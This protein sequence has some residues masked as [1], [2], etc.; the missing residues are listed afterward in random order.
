LKDSTPSSIMGETTGVSARG[1]RAVSEDRSVDPP[2]A[3]VFGAAGQGVFAGTLAA[4]LSHL[5]WGL[6]LFVMAFV[7][8]YS[9]SKL[10]G[11]PELAGILTMIGTTV[12]YFA[13]YEIVALDSPGL[14]PTIGLS[15]AAVAVFLVSVFGAAAWVERARLRAQRSSDAI[16]VDV[17]RSQHW[18]ERYFARLRARSTAREGMAPLVI[19]SLAVVASA[20]AIAFAWDNRVVES[21]VWGAAF[22]QVIVL[23]RMLRYRMRLDQRGAR[24]AL[25]TARS[26]PILFLRPFALD[27]LPVSPL[28]G[29]WY[30]FLNPFAWLDKRT[31]EEHLSSTFEDVGPVIAIGRPGEEVAPLGAAREYAD[32]ATWQDV[33]LDRAAASQFV[34]MEVDATPGMAWELEHV[35]ERVGLRRV[36]IVLP[37]GPDLFEKRPPEWYRR[38]AELRSRLGFLPDVSDDTAAVLFDGDDRPILVAGDQSSVLGTL[39]AVRT[40][41][42]EERR[43]SPIETA[44]SG[45]AADAAAASAAAGGGTPPEDRRRLVAERGRLTGAVARR[46]LLRGGDDPE[47]L[48]LKAELARVAVAEGDLAKARKLQEAVVAGRRRRGGEDDRETLTALRE[49]A[50]TVRLQGDLSRART[51]AER[52]AAASGSVLGEDHPETVRARIELAMTLRDGGE[53]DAA[54]A[55]LEETLARQHA[56]STSDAEERR[57]AER[58]LASVL[59]LSGEFEGARDLLVPV[60]EE[61]RARDE[62][63]HLGAIE[64]TSLLAEALAGLGERREAARLARDALAGFE[65]LLGADHSVTLKALTNA[66]RLS[67]N[68]GDLAEART[69]GERAVEA[70]RRMLGDDHPDALTSLSVLGWARAAQ[71]EHEPARELFALAWSGRRRVLGETHSQTLAA[72]SNLAGVQL[73]LG[74]G[75]EARANLERAAE[76]YERT[77]GAEH[78]HTL[79]ALSQLASARTATGDLVGARELHERVVARA[80]SLLGRRHPDTASMT[81]GLARTAAK[82]G[83]ARLARELL[84]EAVDVL[85][86]TLGEA[87][88]ATADARSALGALGKD[89]VRLR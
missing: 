4:A 32:D 57:R 31:F 41:W 6:N 81:V 60:L 53:L 75:E 55:L 85:A 9:M 47:T 24:L 28:E 65:R 12:L 78:P 66:A 50:A 2:S 74:R 29:K 3:P 20:F 11:W 27:A 34:I 18:E 14:A 5:A 46:S 48:R 80:R 68:A 35:P 39:A 52:V 72:L 43:R 40:A 13:I 73:V 70:S 59:T 86:S 16:P 49:L 76:G 44:W 26:R 10:R 87:H 36:L 83:E 62:G 42:L 45:R 58:T 17:E 23:G 15:L 25:A 82:Q 63:E 77:L 89:E 64:T 1:R 88:A 56:A 71:G 33:V 21:A 61:A 38:W 22:F 19:P 67:A 7:Y 37:P 51:T 84:D 79:I 69:L 8:G 54:R 30:G